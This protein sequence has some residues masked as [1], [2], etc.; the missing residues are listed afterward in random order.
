[1]TELFEVVA[2]DA[3]L[4]IINK[5][6]GLVCHPTK[7]DEYSSLASRIRIY[8]GRPESIHL[9]NR[10]DR[11]TSGLIVVGKNDAAA[12]ELRSKWEAGLVTKKYLAIVEGRMSEDSGWID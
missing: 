11:E 1:M 2:E 6:A 5:P 3:D 12:A 9:I 4:L 10:L 8:L 7:G